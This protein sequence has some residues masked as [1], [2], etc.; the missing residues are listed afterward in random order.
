MYLK[1]KLNIE[2]HSLN[3][4]SLLVLLLKLANEERT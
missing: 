3:V 4:F 2:I 1:Q